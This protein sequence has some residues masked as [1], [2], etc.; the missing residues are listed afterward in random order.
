MNTIYEKVDPLDPDEAVMKKAGDII[1]SGGLVAFPT[2]TVY[3][4]GGDALDADASAKI[5]E[6]KG[7][8]SDNPLIVHIAKFEDIYRIT[9]SVPEEAR[10]LAERFWPGPLTM[11]F[12]KSAI[13]PDKTTGGLDTV[14]VR[15]PSHPVAQKFIEAAGGYIAAPSANIS[16]RPSPT[17]GEHVL[18]D[19]DTRIDMIIDAGPCDIGLESTIIDLSSGPCMMLRPGYVNDRMLSEVIGEVKKDE[20]VFGNSSAAPKAPGMKYRHYA[21]RGEMTIVAGSGDRVVS[22]ITDKINQRSEGTKIAVLSCTKNANRYKGADLVFDVG[23]A[24]NEKLIAQ[25]LYDTLR[26][27]DEENID[28][29][30]SEE[31]DTPSLGLA[32]MNRLIKAAGHNIIRV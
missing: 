24:A 12:K 19:M 3:G 5:Y 25:R 1:R 6:A 32:I 2:E 11:I 27:C 29:I 18:A 7:R 15:F 4:L 30:Y 23:D 28:I 31:F 26:R 13:V 17:N 9:Q 14:A 8:P 16:G 21:P 22:F 10:I 20:A